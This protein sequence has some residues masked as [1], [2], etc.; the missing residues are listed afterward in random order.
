MQSYFKMTSTSKGNDV[1]YIA[2]NGEEI[3]S[4]KQ[5]LKLYE[6]SVG[7]TQPPPFPHPRDIP[8]TFVLGLNK[9]ESYLM[10]RVNFQRV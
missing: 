6:S 7:D 10:W 2:P 3:K 8:S 9:K 1:S 5:L 4:G